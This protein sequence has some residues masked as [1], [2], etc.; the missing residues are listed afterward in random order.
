MSAVPVTLRRSVELEIDGQA[1]RARE[2]ETILDA[3]RRSGLDI[4]TL[5]FGETLTP[6]NAC[7]V[8]MVEVEGSRVLVPSC[9]RNVEDG[10]KIKTASER[11]RHARKMVLEFLGSSVDLSTT[12]LADEWMSEYDAKP[13]RYGPPAP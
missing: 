10:M 3:C 4:P 5:C 9:A 1:V 6:V 11:V 7:R 8:C 12:P 2:G 13:E